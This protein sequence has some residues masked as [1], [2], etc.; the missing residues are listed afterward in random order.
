M[1]NLSQFDFDFE[2]VQG[3]DNAEADCLSR[4]PVLEA[5]EPSTDLKIV[6]FI[7][8]K[9]ILE[10]QRQN[11]QNLASKFQSVNQ[12]KIIISNYKNSKKIVVSDDLAMD[13]INKTF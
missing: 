12:D 13:L 5:S 6:N 4:N 7:E 2:Y 11:I 10:D 9:D 3:T 8:I 1:L